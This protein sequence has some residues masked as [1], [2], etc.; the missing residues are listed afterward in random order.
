MF[1]VRKTWSLTLREEN[2]LNV[3]EKRVLSKIFGPKDACTHARNMLQVLPRI[4]S[5][6]VSGRGLLAAGCLNGECSESGRTARN[7]R[8]RKFRLYVR[9]NCC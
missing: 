5:S 9:V 6:D 7:L 3:F 1:Y 2:R 4:R 8:L